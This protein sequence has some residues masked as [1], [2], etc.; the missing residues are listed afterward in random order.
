MKQIKI[1]CIAVL[2]LFCLKAFPQS[3]TTNKGTEF[4]TAFMQN[5]RGIDNDGPCEMDLYITSDVN[6]TGSVTFVDGSPTQNFTVTANQ[7]TIL[8]MPQSCFLTKAGQFAEGI[9]IIAL[10][11]IVVFAHIH[12]T[13]VSGATL[14]L[15]VPTLGKDYFSINYTQQSNEQPAYSEFVIVATQDSTVVNVTPTADLTTGQTAGSTFTLNMKKGDIYQ[16]F[17]FTDLTGSRI[18][19]VSV[20]TNTCKKIAVFSGSSKL[21]I[22]CS[23]GVPAEP[24]SIGI[25]SDNLFQ[26]VYPTASWGKNYYTVPL[27]QRNYD[28]FRI[29]LSDPSAN[30][31]LNGTALSANQFANGL[32]YEFNSNV[33][34]II[35]SDKPIQVVQY[36]VTQANTINCGYDPNDV[37]DP[38]M[39][40]LTPIE[41][42]I[43]EATLYS[44]PK[45]MITEQFI[46]VIIKSASASTFTIDGVSK[47]SQFSPF[48]LDPTY[49]LGQFSVTSGTH[50]IQASAGFNAIAYG[51]GNAESYGYAA[52][53]NL[54]DLNEYVQV[55]NPA[56]KAVITSGCTSQAFNTNITLPY[57]TNS[58]TWDLKN[59]LPTYTDN[60]PKVAQTT[61]SGSQTL[62]TYNYPKPVIYNKAG[63]YDITVTSFNP[64]ADI[65]GST[66]ITDL[67]FNIVDPPVA[68][69]SSRDTI[70]TTDTIQ[71]HDQTNGVANPVIAWHYNFNNGDTSALQN[72]I[73]SFIKPGDYSVSLTATGSTGCASGPYLKKIHVYALPVAKFT[74]STPDCVTRAV[75]FTDQSTTTERPIAQWVYDFGDGSALQTQTN[76][77]AFT[78][79]F[80]KS[81]TFGVKLYNITD[82]GCSGNTF[83]DSVTVHPLPVIKVT[84]PDVCI[85]DVVAHFSDQSTIA[86]SSMAQFTYLWN[87]GDANSTPLN[88]NTSTAKNPTHAFSNPQPANYNLTLTITS[89]NGCSSTLDTTFTVNGANPTAAFTVQNPNQLCSDHEVFFVNNSSVSFGSVTKIV[90]QYDINDP[91]SIV[92]Y[93]HPKNGQIF[94]HTYPVFYTGPNK[95]YTVR[96]IAYSGGVTCVSQPVD[97]VITLLPVEKLVFA[98]LGQLCVNAAPIQLTPYITQ[99]GASGPAGV[100]SGAGLTGTTFTPSAAGV[101]THTIQYIFTATNACAD[102]ATQTIKVNPLPT[103]S[104]GLDTAILL[105]AKI[106]LIASATG[107]SLSYKWT[108]SVGLNSA[109][110]LNPTASPTQTTTYTLTVTGQGVCSVSASIT[111]KV[112][113]PP[114]IPNTFTPNGDGINDTWVIDHLSDYSNCTVQVFNRTGQTV[115]SSVGYTTPWDGRYNDKPLPV[116]VYYY[117]INPKHGRAA[118]SGYIT[119]VR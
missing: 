5:I 12:A 44:T 108:P 45:E 79:I 54:K 82:K 90:M 118:S 1:L 37:G 84:L 71:F 93:I 76:N 91:T 18:Q 94:R 9:H 104:V 14:L 111:V 59:G 109:T 65:C 74:F 23:P 10:L 26:Q 56:T 95:N 58:L 116:G 110:L 52:G 96:M 48:G 72:P 42:S 62:Y 103:I 119:I 15:P 73:Y 38:E 75:T 11:P 51:F 66:D 67:N 29:I 28:I 99:T 57:Q 100:F 102:T 89:K 17:S 22:G 49:S 86:D 115:Y 117:I 87:F 27:G 80:T 24:A 83:I 63:T 50:T 53:T 36:A 55:I 101:G 98:P 39:I 88:P 70:C 13:T 34:N 114:V 20:G 60:S 3:N 61:Q 78:H 32:Y 21:Y 8:T 46:N 77:K 85:S 105:G 16:A 92:T 25:T 97:V 113:L 40:F 19:S 64:A 7:I 33:P 106:R 31:T 4:W 43:N 2:C 81:G 112:L 6:T 35:R 41:Q 68:K 30:V 69:F 107:D 47:G